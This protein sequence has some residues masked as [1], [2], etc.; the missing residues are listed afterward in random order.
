V[1]K[2]QYELVLWDEQKQEKSCKGKEIDVCFQQGVHGS[3]KF[4]GKDND[5]HQIMQVRLFTVPPHT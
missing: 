3:E 2:V 1:K 5:Q 4:V